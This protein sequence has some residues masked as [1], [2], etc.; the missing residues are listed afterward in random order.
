[1]HHINQYPP[2][3]QPPL[4]PPPQQL[5]YQQSFNMLHQGSSPLSQQKNIHMRPST[6]APTIGTKQ[7]QQQQQP[8]HKSWPD[9]FFGGRDLFD[10]LPSRRASASTQ[11]AFELYPNSTTTSSTPSPSIQ[12]QGYYQNKPLPMMNSK[13]I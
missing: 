5:S 8:H 10:T 11:Y 7:Q 4:S 6:S 9:V 3:I 12:K 13:Y 1:M 2:G